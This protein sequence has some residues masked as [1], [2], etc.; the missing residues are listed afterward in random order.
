ME[1]FD[2]AVALPDDGNV[3]GRDS[4]LLP[5]VSNEP[6]R[7]IECIIWVRVRSF[8]RLPAGKR[9]STL[10][11]PPRPASSVRQRSEKIPSNDFPCN[12]RSRSQIRPSNCWSCPDLGH[13][14]LPDLIWSCRFHTAPF[15]SCV[16]ARRRRERT[17]KLRSRITR[18]TRFRFTRS[19]PSC[20][21]TRSRAVAVGW[22]FSARPE[23][24]AIPLPIGSA[25]SWLLLVVQARSADQQCRCHHCR[26]VSS[27]TNARA[28]I[29]SPQPSLPY[30]VFRISISSDFRP[31]CVPAAGYDDPSRFPRPQR[32]S[33]S[34]AF[35]PCSASS[36][37]R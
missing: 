36:F 24:F 8:S 10:A 25:A 30:D 29:T 7:V 2:V 23:R 1:R 32:S 27:S 5:A 22:L 19:L 14:R 4:E 13:I 15:L 37:Q 12:S 26:R 20:A 33:P 18:N 35:A 11:P 3:R 16:R 21:T 28:W 17:S 9:S 6:R 34:A 31:A